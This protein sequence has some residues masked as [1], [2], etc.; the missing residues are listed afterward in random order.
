MAPTK[1][2]P[3][4]VTAPPP[5]PKTDA[6]ENVGQLAQKADAANAKAET[7]KAALKAA[8]DAVEAAPASKKPALTEKMNVALKTAKAALA[9]QETAN[10]KLDTAVKNVAT[11]ATPRA[12]VEKLSGQLQK[13][14]SDIAAKQSALNML[15]PQLTADVALATKLKAAGG[16]AFN[17]AMR[18]AEDTS[19]RLDGLQSQLT[20]LRAARA[21]LSAEL[22]AREG[23]SLQATQKEGKVDAAKN[24]DNLVDLA[25][26]SREQQIKAV[27]AP[28]EGVSAQKAADFDRKKVSVSMKS[29][30]GAENAAKMLGAQ[31]DGSTSAQQEMLIEAAAGKTGKDNHLAHIAKDAQTSTAVAVPVADAL[32]KSEG[33]ARSALA[34][35]IAKGTS[36]MDSKLIE[37]L[38]AKMKGG[39]G[40][41]ETDAMVQGLRKAGKPALASALEEVR[42]QTVTALRE[43]FA[44]KNTKVTKLNGEL[45][46]LAIGFGPL[47]SDE[48]RQNAILGFKAKHQ[49]DY[50]AWEKSGA[51]LANALPYAMKNAGDRGI[52]ELVELMPAVLSTKDGE[53]ALN[54]ALEQQAAGQ[55]TWLGT[56]P[57]ATS[58]AKDVA[59]LTTDMT[60][61]VTKG[62]AQRALNL[63]KAGDLAGAQKAID[64]LR[65]NSRMFGVNP[66]D[67]DKVVDGMKAV[68]GGGGQAAVKALDADLRMLEN[69]TAGFNGH[70]AQ[71]L[72]GM[73]VVLGVVGAIDGWSKVGSM[74]VASQVRL[75]GDTL[76]MGVD[77]GMV[78]M[79]L[80]TKG[81]MKAFPRLDMLG[82]SLGGAT[83]ALG[84]VL[85]GIAAVQA[86]REGKHAEGIASSASAI[87]GAVL[88]TAAFS[89]AAGAQVVPV[90]G[91]IA[92]VVLVVGGTI[93]KF[94]TEEYRAGKEEDRLEADA[95]AF[96]AGA[97]VKGEALNQ[98]ADVR[99][100]D[101]RNAG[102]AIQQ[103][104]VA[105][106]K[107]P[108]VF[109]AELQKWPPG[110]IE[111]FIDMAK[112]LPV[113]KDGK[114]AQS[115]PIDAK[116]LSPGKARIAEKQTGV[117]L[118]PQSI[119]AAIEYMRDEKMI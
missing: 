106:G 47:M 5:P 3:K 16:P 83:A 76:G 108:K 21:P 44:E 33:L 82:K 9:E 28:V 91:Q 101:G 71:A 46:R 98:I 35:E 89:A 52:P 113:G 20:S 100:K 36:S 55:K 75:M 109:F 51:K 43:D 27:G 104:A 70:G 102:Q 4:P 116:T 90:A 48:Q 81:G 115:S 95:E 63:T 45:G 67:M 118:G 68:L 29:P 25:S 112:D 64:G 23:T 37:T 13:L 18:K 32:L 103:I 6:V 69:S 85:D 62:V 49:A 24:V 96:L 14:D 8:H 40:F 79:D 22:A 84:A 26:K 57:E 86:F 50:N 56:L 117:Y 15:T 78:A 30:G 53:K 73:G 94:A 31:L 80:F 34:L 41:E 10:G 99:R 1:I 61:I 107:D 12:G 105:L 93:A 54:L 114:I 39:T 7:A 72:K 88:A 111:D 97:G 60:T 74:D 2:A 119:R 38:S 42:F 17:A 87:G 19:K 59:K 92:G 58:K 65:A 77:G 110:K 66:G 11:G